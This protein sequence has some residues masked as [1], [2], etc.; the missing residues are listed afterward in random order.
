MRVALRDKVSS[1]S[2]VADD[3]VHAVE[4]D[5]NGDHLSRLYQ[6]DYGFLP[7]R[8]S[9]KAFYHR[10]ANRVC[11]ALLCSIVTDCVLGRQNLVGGVP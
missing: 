7:R 6:E 10:G 3:A 11:D 2:E 9:T 5:S 8:L 1:Q 4:D